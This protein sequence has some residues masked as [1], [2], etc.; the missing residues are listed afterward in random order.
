[1]EPFP[2]FQETFSPDQKLSWGS[3]KLEL[4]LMPRVPSCGIGNTRRHIYPPRSKLP[5]VRLSGGPGRQ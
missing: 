1:M 3:N 2:R 5:R 4:K